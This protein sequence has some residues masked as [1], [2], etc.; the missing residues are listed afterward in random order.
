ML[1][2]QQKAWLG[3]GVAV[4]DHM[5]CHEDHYVCHGRISAAQRCA[6]SGLATAYS[7]VPAIDLCGEGR[8]SLKALLRA[9]TGYG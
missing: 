1:S 3:E 2:V 5:G 6:L 9:K 8:S 7:H 4:L